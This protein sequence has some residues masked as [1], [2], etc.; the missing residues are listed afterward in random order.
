[1]LTQCNTTSSVP[2]LLLGH[3]CLKVDHRPL[4]IKSVLISFMLFQSH[5]IQVLRMQVDWE[6]WRQVCSV[7]LNIINQALLFHVSNF[8]ELLL[9]TEFGRRGSTSR[10]ALFYTYISIQTYMYKIVLLLFF[11]IFLMH[12]QISICIMLYRIQI[13]W[14]WK[15]LHLCSESQKTIC[16][17]CLLD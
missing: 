16:I 8:S 7:I 5:R 6:A 11:Y 13:P 4:R 2:P 12:K 10:D 15:K 9:K 3:K 1:M 14:I 17:C